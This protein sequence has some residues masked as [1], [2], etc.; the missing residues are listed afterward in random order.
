MKV[1][2]GSP[3]QI[4]LNLITQYVIGEIGARLM[5]EIYVKENYLWLARFMAGVR[6]RIIVQRLVIVS[7]YPIVNTS[8]APHGVTVAIY[9]QMQ[10]AKPFT[11]A[12]M[13]LV[14]CLSGSW[15]LMYP[16]IIH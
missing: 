2:I 10:E 7:E 3:I 8:V 16:P 4:L 9:P 15:G 6:T 12:I 13:A 5:E 14:V 11:P 1:A